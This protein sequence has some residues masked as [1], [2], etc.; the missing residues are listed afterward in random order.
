MNIVL[1][2]ILV[3]CNVVSLIAVNILH[4]DLREYQAI[5]ESTM[6]NNDKLIKINKDAMAANNVLFDRVEKWGNLCIQQNE[7]TESVLK[8]NRELIALVHKMK[9]DMEDDLS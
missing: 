7:L 1:L 8:D 6:E 2:A 4:K 5:I 3:I 9:S